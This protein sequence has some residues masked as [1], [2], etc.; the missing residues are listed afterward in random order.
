MNECSSGSEGFSSQ[1]SRRSLDPVEA[2][3]RQSAKGRVRIRKRKRESWGA[4]TREKALVFLVVLTLT[5]NVWGFGGTSWWVPTVVTFYAG[6]AA[7]LWVLLPLPWRL[8]LDA[9]SIQ[10]TASANLG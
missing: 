8:D 10:T 6:L 2:F 3:R 4:S 1:S 9:S 5:F 7:L